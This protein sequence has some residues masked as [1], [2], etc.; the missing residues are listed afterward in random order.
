M[1][2]MGEKGSAC[3]ILVEKPQGR[4]PHGRPSRIWE[5]NIIYISKHQGGEA[6]AWIDLTQDRDKWRAL[7]N[8]ETNLR[9]PQDVGNLL[10]RSRVHDFST[11]IGTTSKFWAPEG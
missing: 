5:N 9:V 8:M 2:R 1:E 4:R 3:R 11:N 7:V 10:T 6:V